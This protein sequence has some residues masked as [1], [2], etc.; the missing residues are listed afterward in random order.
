VRALAWRHCGLT[1]STS[2]SFAGKGSLLPS[3][4]TR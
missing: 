1:S 4:S 2:P 3:I